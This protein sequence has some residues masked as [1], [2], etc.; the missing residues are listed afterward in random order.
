MQRLYT[1]LPSVVFIAF[2][3]GM[4]VL[5]R[6]N[7][8]DRIAVDGFPARKPIARRSAING[9][10]TIML[11][12]PSRKAR[13]LDGPQFIEG[14]PKVKNLNGPP[15]FVHWGDRATSPKI[16]NCRRQVLLRLTHGAR[17]SPFSQNPS[18]CAMS[19]K[20][21]AVAWRR[22]REEYV[23]RTQLAFSFT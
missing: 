13:G 12:H 15:A 14:E 17:D 18:E 7:R 6:R 16:R 23:E 5:P 10:R 2:H 3:C 8:R 22:W 19:S 9:S 11:S 20:S 1:S 21:L 4:R